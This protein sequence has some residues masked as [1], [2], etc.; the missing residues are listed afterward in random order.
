MEQHVKR[1]GDTC[2]R[3]R[4]TLDDSLVSLAT[5]VDIITLDGE[6]FLKDVGCAECLERPNLHLSETLTTELSLTTERLLGNKRV[7]PD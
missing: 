4:L 3:H 1:L 6:D 5:S 7:R 2:L